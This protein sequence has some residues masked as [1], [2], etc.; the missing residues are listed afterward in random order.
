[1]EIES[2]AAILFGLHFHGLLAGDV[3]EAL[4]ELH[5]PGVERPPGRAD[6]L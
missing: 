2:S 5:E 3:G 1:M 4:Y 6:G